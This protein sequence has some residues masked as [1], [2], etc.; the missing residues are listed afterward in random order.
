MSACREKGPSFLPPAKLHG[1]RVVY[2]ATAG[3]ADGRSDVGDDTEPFTVIGELD[4]NLLRITVHY[5]TVVTQYWAGLFIG[6]HH[7][8]GR[9][10]LR[11]RP[12]DVHNCAGATALVYSTSHGT[13]QTLPTRVSISECSDRSYRARD[14]HG[15]LRTPPLRMA[16]Y[17]R[18][19]PG[20]R[21]RPSAPRHIY[22][23]LVPALPHSTDGDS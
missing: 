1:G 22:T 13:T 2:P 18:S 12:A 11:T 8:L 7:L 19:S 21:S 10:P 23:P 20:A 6:R 15:R 9:I 4:G 17:A 5:V 3:D 16:T 14:C